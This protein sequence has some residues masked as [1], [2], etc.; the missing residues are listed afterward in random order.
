VP[1]ICYLFFSHKLFILYLVKGFKALL[2]GNIYELIVVSV[3]M[4]AITLIIIEICILD[5]SQNTSLF[6]FCYFLIHTS[7]KLLSSIVKYLTCSKSIIKHFK[8]IFDVFKERKN[9]DVWD[10]MYILKYKQNLVMYSGAVFTTDLKLIFWLKYK[11]F[12]IFWE[13]ILN[14]R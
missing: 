2:I 14:L 7:S 5:G 9:T 8:S 4:L 10:I 12:L 11:I 1:R 3:V 13:I 6:T